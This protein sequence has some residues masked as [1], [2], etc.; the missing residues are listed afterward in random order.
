VNLIK[1]MIITLVTIPLVIIGFFVFIYIGIPVISNIKTDLL[2]TKKPS[3][4][5][6]DSFAKKLKIGSFIHSIAKK[7]LTDSGGMSSA[8]NN[9]S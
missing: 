1:L 3:K 9:I 6:I 5:I 4:E 7:T 8:D 2:V